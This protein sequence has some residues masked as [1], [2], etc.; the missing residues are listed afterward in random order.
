MKVDVDGGKELRVIYVT[1]D[2]VELLGTT[3]YWVGLN[4]E[5]QKKPL[6]CQV[7][8]END[9]Y[10]IL[11]STQVMKKWGILPDEFP[12]VNRK[13]FLE[14]SE[15]DV[16]I[17]EEVQITIRRIKKGIKINCKEKTKDPFGRS[18]RSQD[19]QRMVRN[20]KVGN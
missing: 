9:F 1:G 14:S 6:K 10:E 12:R 20:K 7:M 5:G 3:V 17:D 8:K 11:L 18:Q 19:Q 4:E 15:E 2:K 16:D 13:K